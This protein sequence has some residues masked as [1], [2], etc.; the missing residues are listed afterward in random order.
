MYKNDNHFNEHDDYTFYDTN[1]LES[2]YASYDDSNLYQDNEPVEYSSYEEDNIEYEEEMKA[3]PNRTKIVIG[4]III[5]IVFL[6]AWLTPQF[7]NRSSK[8][9][10]NITSTK[11]TNLNNDIKKMKQSA[12]KYYKENNIPENI[13]E[14]KKL[15]LQQ[16]TKKSLIIKLDNSYNK[17]KSYIKLTKQENEFILEVKL[18]L[19]N[20]SKTKTYHVNNYSYCTST[21]LCE[22]QNITE[23]AEE[24]E[25]E[26]VQIENTASGDNDVDLYQYEYSQTTNGKLSAWSIWSSYSR[27]N[28]STTSITCSDNDFN[29]LKEL[30]LYNRKEKV[31]TIS[32]KYI[33]SRNS[34]AYQGKETA[35]GCQSYDYMKINGSYYKAPT[36]N[37]F[38]SIGTFSSNNPK[39]H[40]SWIYSGRKEFAQPPN[41]STTTRYVFVKSETS[42]TNCQSTPYY[43]YD[44]YIFQGNLQKVSNLGSECSKQAVQKTVPIYSI[45]G[46]TITVNRIEPL[47]GTV[48][49]QS[50][51]Y[52]TISKK[53]ITKTVWSNYNDQSLLNNGYT[54]TGNKKEK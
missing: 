10:T 20:Q 37:E 22:E 15:T 40:G 2:P 21:Y 35:K 25:T 42:C 5:M 27:T 44:V 32:K 9:D 8:A 23:E 6:I 49:Y 29:C 50:T 26:K 13:G 3:F 45:T 39:N 47:Y 54:Y 48:C 36:T 53:G 17:N 38:T 51:R 31:G 41:D 14:N 24:D 52:R 28:C 19:E 43:T 30:K 16:L 33:S 11:K 12:L 46:Q 1:E 4:I 7:L 18:V 34:Y